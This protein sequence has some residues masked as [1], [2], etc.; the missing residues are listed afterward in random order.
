MTIDWKILEFYAPNCHTQTETHGSK[1]LKLSPVFCAC[2]KSISKKATYCLSCSAKKFSHKAHL[3]KIEWP[4]TDVLLQMLNE[5]NC[6][7]V[8][9]KLGVSDKAIRKHLKCRGIDISKK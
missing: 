6:W 3:F 5:S 4:E 8:S 9:K 2:G 7:Q 1:R